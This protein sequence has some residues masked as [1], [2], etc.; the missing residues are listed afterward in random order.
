VGNDNNEITLKSGD[1]GWIL[2]GIPRDQMWNSFENKNA[3]SGRRRLEM[4]EPAYDPEPR[5]ATWIKGLELFG[6]LH[7]ISRGTRGD[8][9][10]AHRKFILVH[11]N[12]P[13]SQNLDSF[14]VKWA[15]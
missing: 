14:G 7:I 12:E 5:S 11:H 10:L 4:H 13:G 9:T 2:V 1:I 8:I 3:F 15:L 6:E